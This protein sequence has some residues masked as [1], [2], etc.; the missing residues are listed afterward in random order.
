MPERNKLIFIQVIS[1]LLY[2]M[3]S[4]LRIKDV[5]EFKIYKSQTIF[6]FILLYFIL[7]LGEWT[8]FSVYFSEGTL[9]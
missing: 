3:D 5:F 2:L 8:I 7:S 9:L 4:F 6:D 1:V